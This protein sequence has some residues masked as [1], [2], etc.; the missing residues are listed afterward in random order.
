MAA[1]K[2][3]H[4]SVQQIDNARLEHLLEKRHTIAQ[5]LHD[6]TSKAQAENALAELTSA[7]EQIQMAMLKALAKLQD[8]DAADV[9]L[10]V[11]ELTPNK[12]IRKESRR[13]LIQL[14]G[15]KV[16]PSWTPEPEPG[17]AFEITK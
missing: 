6:S 4:S 15:A 5:E 17:P 2:Q 16:Y 7:D 9:L 8:S 14:A 10:A 3:E 11:N 1:K 12:T 13:S